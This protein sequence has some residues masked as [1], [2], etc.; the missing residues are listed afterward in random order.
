VQRTA[1][2]QAATFAAPSWPAAGAARTP[3]PSRATGVPVQRSSSSIRTAPGRLPLAVPAA[4]VPQSLLNPPAPV[5]V[6]NWGA[7][8]T[9]VTFPAGGGPTVQ[10][11]RAQGGAATTSTPTP[12]V[13]RDGGT[14]TASASPGAAA[15]ASGKDA[16]R[17]ERELDELARA[18]FGRIRTRLRS[19]L[20]QDREA[21]GFT[22]DSI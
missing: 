12:T 22:F 20:L 16:A 18:L 19:D 9:S 5:A 14:S 10:T 17:S 15:P 6:P 3:A 1:G 7:P 13:Q 2:N 4:N 11:S 21:A 8:G